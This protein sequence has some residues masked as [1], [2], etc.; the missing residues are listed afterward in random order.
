[1]PAEIAKT[2]IVAA[3]TLGDARDVVEVHEVDQVPELYAVDH[4]DVLVL[5]V[6]ALLQRL[7]EPC[8]R[9]TE[10]LERSVVAP[11]R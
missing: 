5:V 3:L 8:Y 1:M 2:S 10:R 11:S 7:G 9:V 4:L 6:E